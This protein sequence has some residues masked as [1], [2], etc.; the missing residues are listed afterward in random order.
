MK[1]DEA[2]GHPA[3]LHC[4]PRAHKYAEK[5]RTCFTHGELK[6]LAREFNKRSPDA[7]KITGKTKKEIAAKLLKE[8][9]KICDKHQFC[10]IKKT[11]TDPQKISMLEKAFRPQRPLSWEKN[12]GTWLNTYDILYVM[13]QYEELYKDFAFLGV[14]PIDFASRD[15]FD[16]CVGDVLCDFDLKSDILGKKKK[17]FGIV[18]NT[19]DSKSPGMHWISLYCNLDKRHKNFGVYFYD[20]VANPAP[21]EVKA[22]MKKIVAQVNDPAFES[23][24][25]KAQR[26][27]GNNQC[28][29]FSVVFLTQC[30]KNVKFEELCKRM[31][32][33]KDME[34]FRDVLYRPNLGA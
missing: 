27:F 1:L 2:Y 25:N 22:F 29:I 17:R 23:K 6:L 20:S 13:N 5:D 11:L 4:S 18:F 3:E 31:R 24:E 9:A 19:D 14:Y 28:G 15:S 30:L 21:R 10:W 16:R 26:Q 33:D 12:R 34:R 7:P 8:Y 32:R